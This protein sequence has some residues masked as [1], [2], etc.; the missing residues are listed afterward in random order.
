VVPD[1]PAVLAE[2]VTD[3]VCRCSPVPTYPEAAHRSGGVE[4]ID[5]APERM[6]RQGWDLAVCMTDAPLRV[7]ASHERRP[8]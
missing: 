2:R 5:L 6:L 3:A 1:L 7:A 4:A 8:H